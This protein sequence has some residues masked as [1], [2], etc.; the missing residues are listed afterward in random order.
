M[1]DKEV[2]A[3]LTYQFE[4]FTK[5]SIPFTER[6]RQFTSRY[7]NL[8][9]IKNIYNEARA[10]RITEHDRYAGNPRHYNPQMEA[11]FKAMFP[12][13]KSY[14]Q[15]SVKLGSLTPQLLSV[16]EFRGEQE[17][18]D[19]RIHSKRAGLR[20]F[21]YDMLSENEQERHDLINKYGGGAEGRA[22]AEAFM[23]KRR[24]D[25][26]IHSKRAGLR[27]F[28]YESLSDYQKE[29]H[30][31]SEKFGG[32]REGR[33]RAN[34]YINEKYFKG[35]P[36][37]IKNS[38]NMKN[39]LFSIAKA[40]SLKG[41]GAMGPLSV[42][43][44]SISSFVAGFKSVMSVFDYFDKREK[45]NL[46]AD[47]I[48]TSAGMSHADLVLQGKAMKA[49]G[50]DEKDIAAAYK[51]WQT[52]VGALGRGG[53]SAGLEGLAKW[54]VDLTGTGQF[55]FATTEELL[56]NIAKASKSLSTS[57][58]LAMRQSLP[59]QLTD[60]M[61]NAI[62]TNP[63]GFI[64]MLHHNDELRG[65]LDN[66]YN[67][68][69]LNKRYNALKASK[70][71]AESVV[72]DWTVMQEAYNYASGRHEVMGGISRWFRNIFG[73]G[74]YQVEVPESTA[75]TAA[76]TQ[77]VNNSRNTSNSIVIQKMEINSPDG[78]MTAN[79]LAR[80]AT[81]RASIATSFDPGYR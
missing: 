63:D 65:V 13:L 25:E 59:I 68:N 53:S 62:M 71:E 28:A 33:E 39:S 52:Y 2:W 11:V 69:I 4:Q 10:G 38:E 21:T 58:K 44:A 61:W 20:E 26:S 46:N 74:D 60:P 9:M 32:G 79:G 66:G 67:E 77:S 16:K 50:G 29:K 56:R 18:N 31:L 47:N 30:D 42:V 5:A 70:A 24:Q 15:H 57:D 55:G 54:G 22:R 36:K 81:N 17:R 64:N 27:E 1:T 78:K 34:K 49:F 7:S 6:L 37:F 45:E 40:T 19:K 23:N 3:K 76:H 8:G 72:N 48:A 12:R 75:A 73:F 43:G 14:V 41:L 51:S 80:E 35:F